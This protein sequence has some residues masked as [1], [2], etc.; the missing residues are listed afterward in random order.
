MKILL[1]LFFTLMIV[2]CKKMFPDVKSGLKGINLLSETAS[3][4]R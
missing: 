2:L 1:V 3:I 4:A